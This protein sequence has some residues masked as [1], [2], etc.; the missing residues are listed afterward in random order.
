MINAYT[1]PLRFTIFDGLHKP[2]FRVVDTSL[3]S[4]YDIC[5]PGDESQI[6]GSTYLVESRS[7]VVLIQ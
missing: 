7:I 6:V 5:A 4:P 1:E 3:S 2:W